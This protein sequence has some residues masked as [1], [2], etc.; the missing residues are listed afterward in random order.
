MRSGIFAQLAG[1]TPRTL[2]HY[3]SIGLIEEPSRQENGYC[4]YDTTDLVQILRIKRLRSLGLS[5]E[6]IREMLAQPGQTRSEN[7]L[8]QLDKLDRELEAQIT[9]LHL[10]RETIARLKK[11]RLDADLPIEFADIARTLRDSGMPDALL[12][13]EHEALILTD[14][15]L[16]ES[17]KGVVS[18]FYRSLVSSDALEAYVE[19]SKRTHA[20]SEESSEDERTAIIEKTVA[21]LAPLFKQINPDDYPNTDAENFLIEQYR[22]ARFNAAQEDVFVRT[23]DALYDI[24]GWQR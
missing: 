24:L 22:T 8:A 12:D 11:E 23:L 21:I 9:E 15:L 18:A 13:E 17:E 14:S 5:L 16:D 1:V 4:E 20:L 2:R 7:T 19:I 6:T 10:Q 3:R